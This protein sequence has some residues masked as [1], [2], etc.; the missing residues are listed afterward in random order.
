[1]AGT[2]VIL[3]LYFDNQTPQQVNQSF[4]QLLP[5]I[6]A[7]KT[8]ATKINEGKENEEMTV[9]AVYHICRHNQ[10]PPLPCDPEVEI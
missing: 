4:P 10:N 2:R 5:A 9:R 8:K 7:A 1:M 3:D 6:K